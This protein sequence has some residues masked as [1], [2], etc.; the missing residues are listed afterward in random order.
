MLQHHGFWDR[1]ARKFE[2]GMRWSDE[3]LV[4]FACW[5]GNLNNL[6]HYGA[7]LIRMDRALRKAT[8]HWHCMRIWLKKGVGLEHMK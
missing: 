6:Y 5:D 2:R 8:A 3:S 1:D 4:N 7:E